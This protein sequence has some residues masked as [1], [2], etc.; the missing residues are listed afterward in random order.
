MKF[1]ILVLLL[2]AAGI[3]GCSKNT[4]KSRTTGW[5]YNDPETGNIPYI[6]GYEQKAGPRVD[7]H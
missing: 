5:A 4:G 3:M 6:S 1:R 2:L 7:F